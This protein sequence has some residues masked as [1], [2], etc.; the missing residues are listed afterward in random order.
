MQPMQQLLQRAPTAVI[1]T[2]PTPSCFQGPRE[3]GSRRKILIRSGHA[4]RRTLFGNTCL[5][6]WGPMESDLTSN[7]RIPVVS[8][9]LGIGIL[10]G[11]WSRPKSRRMLDCTDGAMRLRSHQTAL[12]P[13]PPELC[14]PGPR[15]PEFPPGF[16]CAK[17]TSSSTGFGRISVGVLSLRQSEL[18]SQ[19]AWRSMLLDW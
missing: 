6:C 1:P 2:I 14:H 13:A 5:P 7:V 10:I 8:S 9:Q 19:S 3:T 17:E 15:T 18:P 11:V 4:R 16:W 12:S